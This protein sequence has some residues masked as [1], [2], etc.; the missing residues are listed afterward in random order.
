M[1]L[2]AGDKEDKD[3][4]AFAP[5]NTAILK[6]LMHSACLTDALSNRDNYQA[7][8][9]TVHKAMRYSNLEKNDV[10]K[11]CGHACDDAISSRDVQA[12]AKRKDPND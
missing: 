7:I 10:I 8:Y 1:F 9:Y 4:A 3:N 12:R 2:N 5:D 6:R 11:V